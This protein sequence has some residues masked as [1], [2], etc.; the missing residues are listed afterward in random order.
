MNRRSYQRQVSNTLGKI[1]GKKLHTH[2]GRKT[3]GALFLEYGFSIEAVSSFLGHQNYQLTAKVYAKITSKKIENEM[4]RI[5]ASGT[6]AFSEPV[7]Q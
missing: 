4:D 3:A 5:L 1:V 2:M 6:V 7:A